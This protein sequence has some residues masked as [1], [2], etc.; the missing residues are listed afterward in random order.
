MFCICLSALYCEGLAWSA[1]WGTDQSISSA[2]GTQKIAG[3]SRGSLGELGRDGV[4]YYGGTEVLRCRLPPS[5]SPPKA[6]MPP[7]CPLDSSRLSVSL[8]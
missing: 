8:A 2:G 6:D 3:Q 5:V 7:E 4:Q 1:S